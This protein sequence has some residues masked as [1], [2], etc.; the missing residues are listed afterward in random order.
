[1]AEVSTYKA[2]FGTLV[3]LTTIPGALLIRPVYVLRMQALKREGSEGRFSWQ[4]Q[5]QGP[6]QEGSGGDALPMQNGHADELSHI[7]GHVGH[8]CRAAP[9]P[10]EAEL[11][12]ALAE[13]TQE[14]QVHSAAGNPPLSTFS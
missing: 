13:A 6:L 5:Q 7:D 14:L 4:Q 12:N 8:R 1:M 10:T 2:T 9:E 3:L 11:N